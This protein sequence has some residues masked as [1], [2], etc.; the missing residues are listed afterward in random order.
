MK[1]FVQP[2]PA[3]KP[4]TEATKQISL[5]YA[6]FLVVMIVAQLYT[7]EEFIELIISF[8]LPVSAGLVSAL[9]PLLV[10]CE[11]FA[12]PFLLRMTISPAFRWVSMACGWIVSLLWIGMTT[13]VVTSAPSIASIGFFG[14]VFD[15]VPGWWAVLISALFGVMAA[16]ASWGMLP[17]RKTKK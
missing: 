1:I 10:A 12:L 11:L 4:R 5:F 14:T 17:V 16:W 6:A 8:D 2:Q 3:P 15:L 13:W 7:F 9:A